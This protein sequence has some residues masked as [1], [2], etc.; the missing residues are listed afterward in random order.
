MET[1]ITDANGIFPLYIKKVSKDFIKL[2]D[3]QGDSLMAT[4]TS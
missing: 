1:H 4:V 3:A 2:M